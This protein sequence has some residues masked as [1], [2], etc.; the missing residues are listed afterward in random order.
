MVARARA[1]LARLFQ[2]PRLIEC[3]IQVYKSA[4]FRI[5]HA[6]LERF[7]DPRVIIFHGKPGDLCA[8]A[9]GKRFE[10]LD[11]FGGTHGEKNIAPNSS[12]QNRS[13]T[14]LNLSTLNKST[15]SF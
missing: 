10:P 1:S 8:F 6:L 12:S 4:G 3:G 15:I 14:A 2:K 9:S 11:N 7:G 5:G 13:S